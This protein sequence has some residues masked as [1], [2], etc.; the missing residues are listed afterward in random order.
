M[1]S[2]EASPRANTRRPAVAALALAISVFTVSLLVATAGNA[3]A[4]ATPVPLGTADSFAVLAG[5]GITNTG[6]TTIDGDVG[7]DPTPSITGQGSITL[8]GAYHQADAVSLQAQTD[9]VTAYDNA[10][11]QARDADSGA[12]LGGKTLVPGVYGTDSALGL[13]GTVTLDGQGNTDGVWVFQAGSLI[14]ASSS[15]VALINGAQACNVYWQVGSSTTLGTSTSFVG[16]IMSLT[17]ITA[18]TGATIQGRL[19]A[20]NGALTLDTNT[21]S[22]P[23]CGTAPPT[24]A[25]PTSGTPS[26]GTPSSGTPSSGTPSSGTPSSETST[27][28]TSPSET[29]MTEQSSINVSVTETPASPQVAQVPVG[30]VDTGDGST[31]RCNANAPGPQFRRLAIEANAPAHLGCRR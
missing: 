3:Q 19:L 9:L 4:V 29:S 14:T 5:T 21:V 26:S 23:S 25:P 31:A 17:T 16:T 2:I 8:L 18:T 6:P 20:R 27:T 28:N 22:R 13:T 30:S 15:S 11:G 1:A 7:T 24:S 10:A 12:E